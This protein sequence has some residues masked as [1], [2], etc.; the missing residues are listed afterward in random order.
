[1]HKKQYPKTVKEAVDTVIKDMTKEDIKIV[2]SMS[3]NEIIMFHHTVGRVIRN[4]FGLWN[5]NLELLN[6]CNEVQKKHYPEE[7][8]QCQNLYTTYEGKMDSPIHPDDASGVI[9]N[10]IWRLINIKDGAK[11]RH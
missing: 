3:L 11:Y 4:H 6:D 2:K 7:Y 8:K 9:L 1:M 5:K 10:E